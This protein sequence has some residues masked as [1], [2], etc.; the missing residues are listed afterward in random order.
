MMLCDNDK[1]EEESDTSNAIG[2]FLRAKSISNYN[3]AIGD[4]TEFKRAY[5]NV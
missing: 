2:N 4:I 5:P 3:S 1:L